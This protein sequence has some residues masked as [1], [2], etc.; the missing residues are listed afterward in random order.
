MTDIILKILEVVIWPITILIIIS[1][2]RSQFRSAMD[3]L[4]SFEAS[5]TGVSMSFEPKLDQ[6][7]K[8]FNE[9]K[10]GGKKKSAVGIMGQDSPTGTPM[11]QVAKLRGEIDSTL[12]EMSRENNIDLNGKSSTTLS[13]ELAD[14]GVISRD[15]SKLLIALLEVLNSANANISQK[16]VDEIREMYNSI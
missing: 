14:K 7:K 2:F 4:G 5:A 8:L 16:Q 11:E 15:N 1:M 13:T 12:L 6:A 10:P 3:R 9:L